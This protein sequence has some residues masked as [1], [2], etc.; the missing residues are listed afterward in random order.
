L[1]YFDHLFKFP[2]FGA[3]VHYAGSRIFTHC[4]E[5]IIHIYISPG[6]THYDIFTTT[7]YHVATLP[8]A[9][10]NNQTADTGLAPAATELTIGRVE[11]GVVEERN[12]LGIY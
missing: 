5:E 12:G 4:G 9:S 11:P 6:L 3:H 7:T 8:A 10:C 1:V 2:T